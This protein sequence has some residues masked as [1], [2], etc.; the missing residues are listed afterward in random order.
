[1]VTMVLRAQRPP[2]RTQEAAVAP[3][4]HTRAVRTRITAG[5]QLKASPRPPTRMKAAPRAAQVNQA[6]RRVAT[7]GMPSMVRA[8]GGSASGSCLGVENGCR[9]SVGP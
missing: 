9:M 2:S 5:D 6:G 7:R 4:N 3:T 8:G 1:M